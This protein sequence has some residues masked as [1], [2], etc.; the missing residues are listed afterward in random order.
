[1]PEYFNPNGHMVHL[2]GPDGRIVKVNG[3]QRVVL[4]E[5]FDRY[6]ARG[7]LKLVTETSKPAIQPTVPAAVQGHV[8]LNRAASPRKTLQ[9]QRRST[10]IVTAKSSEDIAREKRAEVAR[11]QKIVAQGKIH[12]Q[13]VPVVQSTVQRR[14]VVGHTM[15]V[16]AT[17]LLKSN[18]A[19][20]NYPISN[21]IGI[22]ILSYNRVGSLRRLVDSILR[23]TD[24]RRTTVFVS[25]D[26]S[27]E[28]EVIK[29]LDELAASNNFVVLKNPTRLGVAGNSNR[30]L[31]C[32]SRFDYGM[33]LNDDV[34]VLAQGWDTV[35]FHAMHQ[36]GLHHLMYRQ[37]GV[38]G[39]ND[40]VP[41]T[42]NGVQLNVVTERP[43]GAV[44]AFS[45]AML[46]V[47]GY[48][49]E[50]YGLYGMEHVDWSQKAWELGLQER[51]FFDISN[52]NNYFTLHADTSAVANRTELLHSARK[53]FGER[54]VQK[55]SPS[56]ASQVPFITYIVPF[57]NVQ[58]D[59]SIR[60]VINN[61][62]AQRFPAIEIIMVEQ[63]ER[64][65]IVVDRYQPVSYHLVPPTAQPLFNKA[66]AF[67]LGASKASADKLILHDADILTQG[68]Y[69]QT[70]WNMLAN[71]EACHL[72]KAVVYADGSSTNTINAT[73]II[74][75][76][77]VCDRVVGYFEGGSI[78]CQVG[79]FWRCGGFNEDFWGYGVE[80]CDF[81]ARLS[82]SAIWKEDRA[83]DFLH[84]WHGRVSGWNQHHQTNRKIGAK[85]DA[86]PMTERI[87][88]QRR[89]LRN[90]G[91]AAW[92]D[93]ALS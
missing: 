52:S 40:G 60:S 26:G 80:D 67:N 56:A 61:I 76:S 49:N 69:T 41:T 86:M 19:K 27:T 75:E 43:H 88:A 47:V 33:I 13:P 63:D 46:G 74:D 30:L 70:V 2:L 87:A 16:N 38:Y 85:L 24:L 89:Q 66:K 45:N 29:F 55:Y 36:T 90:N 65:M 78:A 64:T 25:D 20:N 9:V 54:V 57:R 91:Y 11:A 58:R 42:K 93:R 81:Y 39:A 7:F 32:L 71:T 37:P 44:L 14:P 5:F 82:N 51:G 68:H 35:Y 18:L 77:V 6:R 34:E 10:Q 3:G 79:A 48:F 4:P 8:Q 59:D 28:P 23:H 72:G 31:R 62:R 73:G 50:G 21:N 84:L 22:G 92:L 15:N 53:T 17:S 83:F 1:M 12:R